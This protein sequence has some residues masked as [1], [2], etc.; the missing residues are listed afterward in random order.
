MAIAAEH[1]FLQR[2]EP[3]AGQ[4]AGA[5]R[6]FFVA[7]G[8]FYA[9]VAI[10]G[11]TPSYLHYLADIHWFAHVHG[12]LMSAWLLLYITQSS[13]AASGSLRLHRKLGL[14]GIWLGALIWLSMCTV[15]VRVRLAFSPAV[16]SFLWDVLLIELLNI[17]LLPIFVTWGFLARR[18]P[19]THKRLMVFSMAV[20]LQ[21]AIDRIRWLPDFGLPNHWGADIYVYGLLL[22]LLLFDLVSSGRIQRVTWIGITALFAGHVAVNLLW[23]APLWPSIRVRPVQR[24]AVGN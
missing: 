13:L 6:Y 4:R 10:L 16:D 22:P 19:R 20:P 5:S 8:A 11:F 3:L 18:E 7:L 12:G 14:G 17:V 1:G 24:V 21:A 2:S 15:S 23:G 9:L